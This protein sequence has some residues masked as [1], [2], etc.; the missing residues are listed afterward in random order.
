MFYDSA[1]EVLHSKRRAFFMK[2]YRISVGVRSRE[3]LL[4]QL[5]SECAHQST[6]HMHYPIHF[7]LDTNP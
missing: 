1:I 2:K 6:R 7:L 3:I 4:R 5:L